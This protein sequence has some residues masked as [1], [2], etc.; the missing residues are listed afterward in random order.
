MKTKSVVTD[1]NLQTINLTLE[2]SVQQVWARVAARFPEPSL[3]LL[4][5][6]AVD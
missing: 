3:L 2:K 5:V 4:T 1:Q 6:T